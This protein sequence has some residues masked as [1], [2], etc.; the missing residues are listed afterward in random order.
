MNHKLSRIIS[1]ICLASLASYSFAQNSS[2]TRATELRSDKLPSSSVISQLAVGSAVQL[3][4]LEGGWAHIQVDGKSGW[5]RASSLALNAGSSSASNV[6]SGREARGNV[7]MTLGV[8]SLGARSNRHALIIGIS[9]YASA[10]VPQLPG[11]KVD[12]E[13]A[14]QMAQAMQVPVSN[15]AY[16]EDDQATA[17]GIRKALAALSDRVVDGDRVFIH[18]SGHGTRYK[19]EAAGGCVEALL[20]YE[21][22]TNAVIPNKEMAKLLEPITN[23]TD[24]LFVMYDACHSGGIVNNASTVRT[25]GLLNGNDEGALRPKFAGISE[26]CAKPVNMKT[27]NLLVEAVAQKALPQDIVHISSSRSDEISFDDEKKGGLATEF[28][29]DCM[30]RDAK[31]LDNSGSIS[32]DE[33]K[34]CAQTK[35]N[36]RMKGDPLYKA[37]NISLTGNA[38]FVP[39]W[40][41]QAAIAST[42]P[43]AVAL[44]LPTPPAPQVTAGKPSGNGVAAAPVSTPVAALPAEPTPAPVVAA[45]PLTG[46]QALKRL[47]EQRDGKRKVT[48]TTNK[49]QLKIGQDTLDFSVKSDKA[50]YVYVALAG[51]DNQ[52]L[53]VLFPND[54][55]KNNRIE[56]G[57][58]MAL[59][60]INWKVRAQGPEGVNQLLVMV[61]DGP[62]DLTALAKNKA[63]PFTASLNNAE[64]R[65]ELGSLMTNSQTASTAICSNIATRKTNPQCSDAFGAGM[66]MI[67]EIK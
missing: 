67:N 63:G 46:E 2:L 29:R 54:L 39:A 14:T 50:G 25:R 61:T 5:V 51:S 18:Y 58:T 62:R 55:D 15:I 32:M 24:K 8:R 38:D 65:A 48:L 64:G 26:E 45:L 4:S 66:L 6:S 22:T 52:S 31:D 44:A 23:K 30:L 49:T 17:D 37:H 59:P 36:D 56:A 12:R 10:A 28:I 7:A 42:A 16:L 53:Y 1:A 20:A 27:R 3:M 57:Q 41:S 43:T 47:F 9:K 21:G 40:F 11:A 19:D 34:Q 33:I 35:I 13:S 60:R